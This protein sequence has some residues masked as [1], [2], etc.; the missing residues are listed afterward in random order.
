MIG[1]F[2]LLFLLGVAS[3]AAAQS[4]PTAQEAH[5]GLKVEPL[6][7]TAGDG[8]R[9]RAVVTKPAAAKE[10]LPAV[11][12]VQALSCDTVSLPAQPRDGW[13]QMEQSLVRDSGALVWRTEKRGVGGSEGDCSKLD[14]ETELADHRAALKALRA[15][16]D[17]D[18]ARI[19]VFGASMGS[20]MAPLLAADQPVAGVA[21]WGGGART[22]AERTLA[23]ERN[24]FELGSEPPNGRAA[25]MSAKYRFI[26]RWLVDGRTPPQIAAE[27]ADLGAVWTRLAGTDA[28]GMYGRPF[29][30]HMQAQAQDWPSAWTRVKAPVLAMF[31]E[32]DWFEDFSG[33]QLIG[34]VVDADSPGQARVVL[35]PGYDHHFARHPDRRSART[36]RGT[37]DAKPVMEVFLP[38]LKERFA[39]G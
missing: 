19:V 27:D 8:T 22:W 24:R 35:F 7:L 18:P 10:R 21:V 5:P 3:A 23:F 11:L 2:T 36:S 13:E 37:P 6:V 4:I 33:V 9:L 1:R 20:N 32:Y 26:G 14:Y 16:P 28:T 12:Y 39:G 38:W 15:R 30:F 29:A 25:E 31:G 34:D 17:V